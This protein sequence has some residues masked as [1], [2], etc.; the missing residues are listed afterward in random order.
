MKKLL[1]FLILIICFSCSE[2][3]ATAP[4]EI[5]K[6]WRLSE[7]MEL[8]TNDAETNTSTKREIER[9]MVSDGYVLC[10]FPNNTYTAL[11]GYTINEG[12]WKFSRDGKLLFGSNEMQIDRFETKRSKNFLISDVAIADQGI[13]AKLRWVEEAEM[14]E[15]FK[16]DPFYSANNQWRKKPK[17]KETDAQIR[18][19]L[20]N[21]IQH[22]ANILNASTER[23]HDVVSFAHSMG[24]IRVYRGGIGR[25]KKENIEK[26]W[27]NCFYDKEDAMKAYELFSRYLVRGKYKGGT[28]GDWVKDDYN[29]LLSIYDEIENKE[30]G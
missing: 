15:D 26:D 3:V 29:I 28:T 14:L 6:I 22:F 24:I 25:V 18:A 8:Q 30:K 5:T 11:Q 7:V 19:R 20:L 27:I 12:N 21:Y 23:E 10:F 17:N 1:Y 2:E 16:E 4:E 13:N 9:K